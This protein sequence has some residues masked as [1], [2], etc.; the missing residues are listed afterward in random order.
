MEFSNLA[1]V[2]MHCP[3]CGHKVTGYRDEDGGTRIKCDRCKAVMF[4]KYRPK[5][6]EAVIRVIMPSE[7]YSTI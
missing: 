5:K 4:S 3:N 1:P 2:S 7:K 6:S